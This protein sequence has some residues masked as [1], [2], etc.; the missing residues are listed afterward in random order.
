MSAAISAAEKVDGFTRKSVRKAQRQKR[1]Q[2][3][4]QFRSQSSQVE[5][6]PLPQLKAKK[7]K[8]KRLCQGSKGKLQEQSHTTPQQCRYIA[9]AASGEV[10][11]HRAR[12]A[13]ASGSYP[14][15]GS[16]ASP[17]WVGGR[18]GQDFLF[19]CKKWLDLCQTHPQKPPPAAGSSAFCP[20]C[21]SAVVGGVTVWG[22]AHLTIVHLDLPYP[23]TPAKPHPVHPDPP[24]PPYPNSTP[25]NLNPCIWIPL[26]LDPLPP[27]PHL[28]TQINPTE[29]PALNPAP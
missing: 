1:S 5:L 22:A 2:G 6:S 19:S 17:S 24:I 11:H 7:E 27:G 15:P 23:V 20:H 13:P 16:D 28:C 25:M 18:R 26:H 3:S 12:D 29:L 8:K 21:S 9:G 10:N 14:D 4:S